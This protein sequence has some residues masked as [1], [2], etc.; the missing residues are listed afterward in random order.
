[1]P[2][3]NPTSRYTVEY[4]LWC[5]VKRLKV[6]RDSMLVLLGCTSGGFWG[7]GVV[8]DRFLNCNERFYLYMMAAPQ[9]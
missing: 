5:Y 2:L 8:D 6:L 3:I 7:V 4:A 9:I 1:M